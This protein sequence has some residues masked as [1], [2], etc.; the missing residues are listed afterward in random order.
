MIVWI[1]QRHE[2][3]QHHYYHSGLLIGDLKEGSQALIP[4]LWDHV[5]KWSD[6]EQN[7][8]NGQY[9]SKKYIK[10]IFF[11]RYKVCQCKQGIYLM[12]GMNYAS[13]GVVTLETAIDLF[14]VLYHHLKLWHLL[15]ST[16]C[17]WLI[18]TLALKQLQKACQ[19]SGL[20]VNIGRFRFGMQS[21]DWNCFKMSPLLLG[22]QLM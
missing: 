17:W 4:W 10:S 7:F 18:L 5:L 22:A 11:S 1:E 3:H 2:K 8:N 15:C 9:R 16:E 20:P 14:L 19:I 21:E 13:G 6:S 12:H